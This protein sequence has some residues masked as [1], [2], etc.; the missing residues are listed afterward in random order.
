M[1]KIGYITKCTIAW[2][3]EMYNNNNIKQVSIQLYEYMYNF[4]RLGK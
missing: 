4:L 1:A 2:R 3:R